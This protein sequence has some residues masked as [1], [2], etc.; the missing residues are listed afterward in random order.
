MPETIGGPERPGG[1]APP[2]SGR[3]RLLRSLRTPGGRGQWIAAV[4]LGALGFA[5]AVQVRSQDQ[6]DSF[7]GA[8]QA[9]L[10]ALINSLALATD[11]A[12]AQI[13]DLQ[14]TRDSLR[15]DTEASN[16]AVELA[17]ERIETLALL[18]GQVPATG[19]G[20]RITVEPGRAGVGTDQLLNGL[21]ELRDAG[22]EAIELND[23]I[24]VVAQT[25]M[26]Q[27]GAEI[28]VDGTPLGQP[29]TIDA[30]GDTETLATALTFDGGFIDEVESIGGVVRVQDQETV[31]VSSTTELSPTRFAL[32]VEEG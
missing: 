4:L 27:N 22:A 7:T 12:E 8:R 6:A 14:E 28:E 1:G 19:P 5:S 29:V 15:V 31:E 13:A 18:A 30:I 32:P 25:G 9:D 11:R 2:P 3:D 17:R 21:Q 10:I 24:R 26:V 23:E 16:T 20:I